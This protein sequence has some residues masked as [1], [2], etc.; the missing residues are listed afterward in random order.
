M[1]TVGTYGFVIGSNSADRRARVRDRY[2]ADVRISIGCFSSHRLKTLKQ[3]IPTS[4]GTWLL[5][6]ARE[7]PNKCSEVFWATHRL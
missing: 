7:E 2:M 1:A 4:M 3:I 6:A 5:K